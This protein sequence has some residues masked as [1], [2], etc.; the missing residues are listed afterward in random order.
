MQTAGQTACVDHLP[1]GFLGDA[2]CFVVTAEILW[3]LLAKAKVNF[4]K[5]Y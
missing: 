5:E 3:A 1:A 2:S 4:R